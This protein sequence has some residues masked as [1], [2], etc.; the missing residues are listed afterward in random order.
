MGQVEECGKCAN[1]GRDV[2]CR[3]EESWPLA[4]EDFCRANVAILWSP[5]G[6]RGSLRCVCE[7]QLLTRLR[8]DERRQKRIGRMRQDELQL[9]H[10][11]A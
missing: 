9:L 4:G 8:I 11:E 7:A 2:G 6:R 1:E 5:C 10:V 3:V